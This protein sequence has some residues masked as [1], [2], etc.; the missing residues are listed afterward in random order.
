M[1]NLEDQKRLWLLL[2][3]KL[4]AEEEKDILNKLGTDTH[5]EAYF[6]KLKTLEHIL[7]YQPKVKISESLKF[8][9]LHKI[10]H[11]STQNRLHPIHPKFLLGL[12]LINITV[13]L[14]FLWLNPV[15]QG[16]NSPTWVLKLNV[17]LQSQFVQIGTMICLGLLVLLGIDHWLKKYVYRISWQ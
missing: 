5:L 8:Q 10:N 16:S 11:Q 3:N 13:L 15:E 1:I 7:K 9:I 14:V 17:F 4:T 6:H 12:I 2:D